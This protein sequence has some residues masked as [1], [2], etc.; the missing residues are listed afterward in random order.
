M[1]DPIDSDLDVLIRD[2]KTGDSNAIGQLLERYRPFLT[3]IA[4]WQIGPKL[5]KRIDATDIV[6][7]TFTDA[8]KDIV[9]FCGTSENE[10]S[11]W[12]QTI[13]RNKLMNV[14]RNNRAAIRDLGKEN[15][16]H[17]VG[18]DTSTSVCW[19]DPAANT[20]S[21]SQKYIQGEKALRL[22]AALQKLPEAQRDAVRM[23][24]LEGMS[25]TEI[26]EQLQRSTTATAG[27]I[28]RG[29]AGL[30][31]SLGDMSVG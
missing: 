4:E 10:F 5:R 19:L 26:A 22:A 12:L 21:P 25:L 2:A 27:L 20:L 18:G 1:S 24:H 29:L 15:T 3:N 17:R 8:A 6:Q 28:K 9:H 14:F 7:I 11:A 16:W 23:R 31:T 30:R 13:F